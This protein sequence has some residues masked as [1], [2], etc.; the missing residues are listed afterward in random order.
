VT[1]TTGSYSAFLP[2]LFVCPL[3]IVVKL[4]PRVNSL[5]AKY[6]AVV[7]AVVDFGV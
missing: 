2:I 4:F 3:G 1:F 7:V 5:A 6:T